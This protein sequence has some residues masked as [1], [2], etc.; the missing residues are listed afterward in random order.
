MSWTSEGAYLRRPLD[1]HDKLF[2]S[3]AAA[4]APLGR[5]HWLLA[6]WL[7]LVF[8]L[9]V[10]SAVR[11]QRLRAAWS[12]L[13]LL[14]PDIALTLHANEKQYWPLLDDED[15]QRW[16]DATFHIEPSA[17][18]ADELFSRHLKVAPSP[19]TTCHWISTSNE[20]VFV[21]PHWRIDGRGVLMLL[22]SFMELLA[23]SATSSVPTNVVVGAEAANLVP[24]LD[25][26]IGMPEILK[27]EWLRKADDILAPFLDGSP[28]I[29]LPIVLAIPGDTIRM[30]TVFPKV[31]T[32]ALREACR[33][34]GL[35]L[36]AALHASVVQETARYYNQ[37]SAADPTATYKS[38]AAFDLRK[39]CPPPSDPGSSIAAHAA[40]IRLVALP[41]AADPTASWDTMAAAFQAYY[42]Q[43]LALADSDALFVRVPYVEKATAMLAKAPPTTE[44]NLSN[45]GMVEEYLQPSY[46]D[47][48]VRDAALAVQML[49]PQLYVHAWSWAGEMRV[50]I[51][52][53]EAFYQEQFVRG[54]LEGLKTNLLENLSITTTDVQVK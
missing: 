40:S 6:G 34:K 35:R 8:P 14:H 28:A 49:S 31:V 9:V 33:A 7:Q 20:V 13:R 22:H 44:P 43:S 32:A 11:E 29:G 39:H 17:R 37:G 27:E 45:L 26:V 4:G 19:Y 38:W 21:T 12:A 53:N 23:R 46:G 54:W 16:T 52:Y 36:T 3:I 25:T 15:L 42:M 18:S 47:V 30:E 10:D 24:T 1:C 48:E 5:E 2:Q 50:S 51:C 41:L